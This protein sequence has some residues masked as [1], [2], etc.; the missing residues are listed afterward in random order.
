MFKVNGFLP[1]YYSSITKLNGAKSVII[2]DNAYRDK[3]KILAHNCN[4]ISIYRLINKINGNTYID[5]PV[6]INVR[7]YTYYSLRYLA[8]SNT[9]IDRALLK[10]GFFN[11]ALEIL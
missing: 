3:L 5:S 1:K 4:K 7:L 6:N 9:L 8:I 11:F 10:H 2:Y